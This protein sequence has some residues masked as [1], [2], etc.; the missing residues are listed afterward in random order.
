MSAIILRALL[1][2][3]GQRARRL[4]RVSSLLVA[5]EIRSGQPGWHFLARRHLGLSCCKVVD[6]RVAE[7]LR[8]AG[9]DLI[10]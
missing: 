1:G 2:L 6:A 8:D 4:A 3:K 10:K 7:A 9:E 5:V